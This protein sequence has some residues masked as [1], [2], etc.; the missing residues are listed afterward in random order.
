ML[1]LSVYE[2]YLANDDDLSP[3]LTQELLDASRALQGENVRLK[4][5]LV[6]RGNQ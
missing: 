5:Q 1:D 3:E 2:R 6:G 4:A